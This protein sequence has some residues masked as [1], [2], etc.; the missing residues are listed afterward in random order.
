[1]VEM[2]LGAIPFDKAHTAINIVDALRTVFDK[3]LNCP[4]LYPVLTTDGASNMRRA[5]YDMTGVYW[6]RCFLHVIHC[7]ISKG[8]GTLNGRT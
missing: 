4:D 3:T 6:L 5:G 2:S 7:A 8:F 1:M